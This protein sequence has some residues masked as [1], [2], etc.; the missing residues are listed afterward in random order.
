MIVRNVSVMH[1]IPYPSLDRYR[2]RTPARPAD[3]DIY[4]L[5]DVV[6]VCARAHARGPLHTGISLLMVQVHGA[7][8]P[9][10][11]FWL[12]AM[13]APVVT[14]QRVG[15]IG[16]TDLIPICCSSRWMWCYPSEPRVDMQRTQV[17]ARRA[18]AS[19]A[20]CSDSFR[21]AYPRLRLVEDTERL[22]RLVEARIDLLTTHRVS[23][24][25]LERMCRRRHGGRASPNF[26]Y[27]WQ[28]WRRLAVGA[29]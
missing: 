27:L 14:P 9:V 16:G 15:A 19:H 22:L 13:I 5:C 25:P 8:H 21:G 17:H 24:Q 7:E 2:S 6:C 23:W 20:W 1:R 12:V 4:A 11:N 3:R 28:R 10:L 18:R 29:G 26:D